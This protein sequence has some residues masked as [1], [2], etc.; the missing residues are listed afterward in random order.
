MKQLFPITILGFILT[1]CVAP[2]P[3]VYC[4]TESLD[5][6]KDRLTEMLK[7]SPSSCFHSV[8][9]TLGAYY[10]TK[11]YQSQIAGCSDS[12]IYFT[13]KDD[14][15]VEQSFINELRSKSL[16]YKNKYA[17]VTSNTRCQDNSS[18]SHNNFNNLIP[19]IL[20]RADQLEKSNEI[21]KRKKKEGHDKK[22]DEAHKAR[23]AELKAKQEAIRI[24][25][26]KKYYSSIKPIVYGNIE[27]QL[28]DVAPT[29]YGKTLIYVNVTNN[30]ATKIEAVSWSYLS[31][32]DNEQGGV[33][34][35]DNTKA[36]LTDNYGN[37]YSLRG[38]IRSIDNELYPKKTRKAIFSTQPI[39]E[40]ATL[41]LSIPTGVSMY[42]LKKIKFKLK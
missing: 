5:K 11:Q 15:I 41:T 36:T 4:N 29:Q 33:S 12:S 42:E 34:Y 21:V 1:G 30:S 31:S 32:Y 22:E 18:Y 38:G 25:E 24:S 14:G 9:L 13:D 6:T 19:S 23:Q 17:L 8:N 40:N 35:F 10:S 3:I 26:R 39:V 20:K 16:Y 2:K 7:Y 27:V 28:T 37:S